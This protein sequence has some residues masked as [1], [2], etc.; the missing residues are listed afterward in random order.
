MSALKPR[1]VHS[2]N[3]KMKKAIGFLGGQFGDIITTIGAQKVFSEDYP[4]YELTL[5]ISNKY[6]DIASLFYNQQYIKSVHLWEGYDQSWPTE[7]DKKFIKENSYDMIFNPMQGVGDHSWYNRIHQV[8]LCCERY[9]LRLPAS[10]EVSLIKHFQT[11]DQY[12]NSIC[13][14]IFPNNG[15]GIKSLSIKKAQ[16]LVNSI[17]KFG[18]NVIQLCGPNDPKL[19]D[20]E[21]IEKSFIEVVKIITSCKLLITG[22]TSMSWIASAYKVP[23]LGIYAYNYHPGAKTSKNWQPIN[24]NAQY[25]EQDIVENIDN[26]YIISILQTML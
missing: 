4:D 16:N 17:K 18:F 15:E 2:K 23:T 24:P 22:D 8:S 1:F 19:N 26:D 12:K 9:G 11:G 20:V 6:S 25:L 7:N 21:L 13:L 5:G 3:L 10:N 14:S